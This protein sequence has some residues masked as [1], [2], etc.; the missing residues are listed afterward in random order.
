MPMF[1]NKSSCKSAQ[2]I[3]DENEFDLHENEDPF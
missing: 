3:S 1:Q 2:N